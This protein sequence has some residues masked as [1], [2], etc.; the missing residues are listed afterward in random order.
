MLV[1]KH[2]YHQ[3]KK[4]RT[5]A[6]TPHSRRRHQ[7]RPAAPL[8]VIHRLHQ[9]EGRTATGCLALHVHG[10]AI[11]NV[12]RAVLIRQRHAVECVISRTTRTQK[13]RASTHPT[14][15]TRN[16]SRTTS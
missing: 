2:L 15:T 9:N 5:E 11:N 12:T 7:Q 3:Q 8:R 16:S 4:V 6:R 10:I 1:V 14:G 13:V